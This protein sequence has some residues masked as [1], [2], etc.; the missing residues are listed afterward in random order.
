MSQRVKIW[1]LAV[2]FFHWSQV[3]L[4]AA[5]WYTG[6]Q[7]MVVSHQLCGI[8]LLALVAARLIWGFCGSQTA[9]FSQFAASP[10]RAWQYLQRPH[11]VTGH[12]P[13]SFYMI[14]LLLLLT[15]TQLLTGLASFDNSYML[16]GPLVHWLPQN[17]VDAASELHKLNVNI[18]L[19]AVVLHVAA[20][21]WHSVRV[22]NVLWP[23]FSGKDKLHKT[24]PPQLRNSMMFFIWLLI[25]LTGLYFWHGWRI[26]A[27]L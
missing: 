14:I 11:A 21:F 23:M 4:L 27:L 25:L 20:A 2:R 19:L 17:W 9:R 13:L 16:D 26:L 15:L 7:G 22:H 8:M 24:P 1:D 6:E 10:A 5:L 3:L 18:L 12:N